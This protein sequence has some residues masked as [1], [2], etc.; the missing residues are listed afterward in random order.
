MGPMPVLL[1]LLLLSIVPV[2]DDDDEEEEDDGAMSQKG[3]TVPSGQLHAIAVSL[4]TPP[5][6]QCGMHATEWFASRT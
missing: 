5:F 6:R 4:Y 3:W 2:D 1:L